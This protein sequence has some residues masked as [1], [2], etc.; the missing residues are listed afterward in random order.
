MIVMTFNDNTNLATIYTTAQ[1]RTAHFQTSDADVIEKLGPVCSD[2]LNFWALGTRERQGATDD[3][4]MLYKFE[5]HGTGYYSTGAST[6]ETY[7]NGDEYFHGFKSMPTLPDGFA[8]F[9]DNPISSDGD[10]I[11]FCPSTDASGTGASVY[12][13]RRS[14]FR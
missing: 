8:D 9:S 2:G 5:T 6:Y 12:R 3:I 10:A 7:T 14:L 11:W 13:L 4:L 1:G